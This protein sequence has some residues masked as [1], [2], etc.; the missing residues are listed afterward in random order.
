[1]KG[2]NDYEVLEIH[3]SHDLSQKAKK[4]WKFILKIIEVIK[5]CHQG[6]DV[7]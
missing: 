5:G 4:R 2:L 1:M 6:S 3:F 7:I